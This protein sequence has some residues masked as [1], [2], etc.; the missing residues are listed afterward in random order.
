M[1]DLIDEAL[2]TRLQSRYAAVSWD[3]EV[4]IK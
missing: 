4:I 3:F 2:Y 1:E